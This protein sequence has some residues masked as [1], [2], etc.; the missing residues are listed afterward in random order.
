LITTTDREPLSVPGRLYPEEQ[1]LF[2][3]RIC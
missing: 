1:M 3:K 2:G